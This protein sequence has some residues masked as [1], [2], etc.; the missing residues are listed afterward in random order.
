MKDS[1]RDAWT[2]TVNQREL[3]RTPQK[4]Y[5]PFLLLLEAHRL[6]PP[7]TEYEFALPRKFRADYCW[8]SAR[9]II[10]KNGGIFR[11]GK[12]G[13]SGQGGHSMGVGILR[14]M[15]KS[16]LAQLGGW[17]YLQYTPREL[18]NGVPLDLLKVLIPQRIWEFAN[19]KSENPSAR[20]ED[21]PE[22]RSGS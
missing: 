20:V 6:P 8:R 16:N 9:L 11:G 13:G 7:D 2:E 17:M 1:E 15:E 18:N 5:D 19:A 21:R 3:A 10:E 22:T 12:G 4:K 14:D